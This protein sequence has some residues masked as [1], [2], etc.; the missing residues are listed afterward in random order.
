MSLAPRGYLAAGVTVAG[1]DEVGVIKVANYFTGTIVKL[2]DLTR[3]RGAVEITNSESQAKEFLPEDIHD[4][5]ELEIHIL[6]DTQLE[7]PWGQPET[8]VITY[9]LRGT[10]SSHAKKTFQGFLIED[11]VTHPIMGNEGMLSKCKLK[12]SGPVVRTAADD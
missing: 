10:A 6:H 5:G 9:P 1:T 8:I 11:V 12:I 4:N 2:G 3:K 7:P